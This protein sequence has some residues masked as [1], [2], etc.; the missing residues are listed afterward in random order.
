MVDLAWALGDKNTQAIQLTDRG[1]FVAGELNKR[2]TFGGNH[3]GKLFHDVD[4][5]LA[6][7]ER[8]SGLQDVAQDN[9]AD[10]LVPQE[11]GVVETKNVA[12]VK[13][14]G[15]LR[16]VQDPSVRAIAAQSSAPLG[17]ALTYG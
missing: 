3:L 7:D 15:V 1:L 11:F 5:R 4:K 13:I 10:F 17:Q 2:L 9:G 14:G 12:T 16:V 6:I 8:V